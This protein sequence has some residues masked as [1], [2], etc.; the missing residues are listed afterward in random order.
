MFGPRGVGKSTLI[1]DQLKSSATHTIDLL[2]D[3]VETRYKKNPDLLIA[4]VKALKTKECDLVLKKRT[5][6]YTHLSKLF[7]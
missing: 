3:E 6:V 5:L 1:Q 4:D 7:S 2:L